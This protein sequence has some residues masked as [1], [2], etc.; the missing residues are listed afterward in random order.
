[1]ALTARSVAFLG[2]LEAVG[3]A[4]YRDSSG[5]WTWSLG[6]TAASGVQIAKY[7]DAAADIATCLHAAVDVLQ[8]QY[9]P[10]VERAFAGLVLT[11]AQISAAL[12]F[13]WNTGAIGRADWV[14]KWRAGDAAAARASLV[15]NWSSHGTLKARRESERD[16]FFDGIWPADMRVRVFTTGRAHHYRP[17][18][19]TL[20]DIVPMLQKILGEI[21]G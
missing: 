4:A 16:L 20:T 11:D 9:L 14:R 1:M 7:V 19:G 5:I 2:W 18:A 17:T 8:R 15:D 12:S 3:L 13:Q 6:L 10:S 21:N